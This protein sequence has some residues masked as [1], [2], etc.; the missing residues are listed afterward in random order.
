MK[1]GIIEPSYIIPWKVTICQ[2]Y[3]EF[4]L[5]IPL[6]ELFFDKYMAQ[7][8]F[9]PPVQA[10]CAQKMRGFLQVTVR[11]SPPPPTASSSPCGCIYTCQLNM[12]RSLPRLRTISQIFQFGLLTQVYA[13]KWPQPQCWGMQKTT[14]LHA[15]S[16]F[17]AGT[18]E[19]VESS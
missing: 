6:S 8:K 13:R 5:Q 19:S 12:T 3:P 16:L 4:H 2:S 14:W 10:L 7:Y 11:I 18:G 15:N 17:I 1:R 9:A